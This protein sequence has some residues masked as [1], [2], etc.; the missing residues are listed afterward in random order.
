MLSMTLA[1]LSNQI[2]AHEGNIFEPP[3]VTLAALV[4]ALRHP[5][6]GFTSGVV[7]K[8]IPVFLRQPVGLR[9]T[10]DYMPCGEFPLACMTRD[11]SFHGP[12]AYVA[13]ASAIEN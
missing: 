4:L 1:L 5:S 6:C 10:A 9:F 12:V 11:G 2:T 8:K 7:P 3:A 13:Y